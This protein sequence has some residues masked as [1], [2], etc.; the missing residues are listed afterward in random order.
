MF[1]VGFFLFAGRKFAPSNSNNEK[2][3][4]GHVFQYD[5]KYTHK[6]KFKHQTFLKRKQMKKII[7]SS[8]MLISNLIFSQVGI[9]TPSPQGAFHVDGAKD[10]VSTGVPTVAQQS[11]DFVVLSNG[12]VGVG[13]VNPANKL[14]IRSATRGAIKIVDGTQADGAIFTSDANGVG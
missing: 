9:N 1:D 13:T 10:N 4:T 5:S 6:K 7:I 12:N 3:Q 2:L 8:G 14:D 11:N